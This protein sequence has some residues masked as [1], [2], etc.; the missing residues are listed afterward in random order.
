MKEPLI[1]VDVS[2]MFFRAFYAIPNLT[3][4]EGFP[5]NA[6]YGFLSMTTKL[7]QQFDCKKMIYCFDRAEPSFRKELDERYKANRTI[8]PEDLGKQIPFI[9]DFTDYLGI[10]RL[11][12]LGFEADDLIGSYA[13]WGKANGYKVIIVSG[14]KDFAQ[15]ISEDVVM[16]DTMK[17][18]TYDIPTVKK[19][20]GVHPS[21]FIDYL[22]LIGDSS[23]NIPGVR[24]I[25]PKSAQKLI[26]DYKTLDGIYENI[27]SIKGAVQKK[28]I[29]NK[30]EAYLSKT[31]VTIKVDIDLPV[32]PENI[33]VQPKN[34][35]KLN[36]LFLKFDFKKFAKELGEG[37]SIKNYADGIRVRTTAADKK[38]KWI[39]D[40]SLADLE[41]FESGSK[42][43]FL[44]LTQGALVQSGDKALIFKEL[45]DDFKDL[46]LEKKFVWS[47]FDLKE[48]WRGLGFDTTQ[49]I[50]FED[51]L[52][53]A[54][55]TL[56]A[57][58]ID[59]SS[60]H[61]EYLNPIVPDESQPKELLN[62]HLALLEKIKSQMPE[63]ILE[64]YE[65]IEK[66]CMPVLAKM[67]SLGVRVDTD[68]L[69][70]QSLGLTD[71]LKV[72]EKNIHDLAGEEFNINSPKQ[73]GVI[74]FEKLKIPTTKKNKTGYSTATDVLEK[75]GKAYPIADLVLNY[76]E[77]AKLKSTYVDSLPKLVDPENGRIHTTFKQALTATGRLSSVNPNLQNIPIRT[78]RGLQIRKAFV[79]TPGWDLISAD[80]SQIELRILA[81]I[82]GDSALVKAYQADHDIH[83][84]TASEIFDVDLKDVSKDQRRTAKAVNFGIA[85][86]QGA[87]GL[88]EALNISRS[89]SKEIIERYFQK[90][91]G[92]KTYMEDIVR[93]AREKGYVETLLGRRRYLPELKSK[94]RMEQSFGERAAINAPMQGTQAD[95]VKLAMIK[96][97]KEIK[98]PMILQVHDELIFECESS[99]TAELVP[100]IKALMENVYPLNVPLVVQ[101]QSGKNWLEAH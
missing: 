10:P 11:D 2:S 58:N 84:V 33:S 59:F 76:R 87:Y 70:E 13:T 40:A 97:N 30:A 34:H 66:P 7:Q 79:P 52:M 54:G 83:A 1:L 9:K 28:L 96:A 19:K 95:I 20:W 38:F 41:A 50:L 37:D 12:I 93:F 35:E 75:L 48:I 26:E 29:E 94:N 92:V 23:D 78:E 65:T 42:I 39:E 89:E 101:C 99:M 43:Y 5:T 86:G 85:Y 45:S 77:L 14:D 46:I 98:A 88:A 3:N 18:V 90:F 67:E 27:D 51:D 63:T 68:I 57:G 8:M 21:E 72:L 31:L 15:L 6:L 81:H 61:N 4:K 17:D 69:K 44:P 25:G 22:A 71:D 24:G 62:S 100:Q 47:G 80:Y 53:L 64:V 55:Y 91:S 32:K 60:L 36:E 74:L 49:S 56:K 16:V 73:L 82:A